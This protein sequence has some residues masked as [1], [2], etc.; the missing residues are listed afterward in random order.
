LIFIWQLL[1]IRQSLDN[2][3]IVIRQSFD[4]WLVLFQDEA[5]SDVH[6]DFKDNLKLARDN[7]ASAAREYFNEA[8]SSSFLN[9]LKYYIFKT[10]NNC[11]SGNLLNH[12]WSIL[13]IGL[14]N[15]GWENFKNSRSQD[16]QEHC[17][18]DEWQLGQENKVKLV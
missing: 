9:S 13:L 17:P 10:T 11:F 5:R 2:H 12:D 18:T 16:F 4:I 7:H 3:L 8:R 15:Y 1:L 14:Q 6:K